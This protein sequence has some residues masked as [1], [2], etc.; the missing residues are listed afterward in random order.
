MI[1]FFTMAG[2]SFMDN[3]VHL[4]LTGFLLGFGYGILQPLFQLFVTGTTPAPKRGTAN[5]AYLLFYDIGIGSFVMGT[6][7]EILPFA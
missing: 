7:S 3:G 6:F 2:D 5:A 4:L 1:L